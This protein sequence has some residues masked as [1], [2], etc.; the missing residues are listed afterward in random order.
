MKTRLN[1]EQG[2]RSFVAPRWILFVEDT[3]PVLDRALE[4]HIQI[5]LPIC[6]AVHR[7]CR[8]A[9]ADGP[10]RLAWN[11]TMEGDCR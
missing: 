3:L 1:P 8:E 6:K 5:K 4:M 2:C 10:L 7:A 9:E 11:I